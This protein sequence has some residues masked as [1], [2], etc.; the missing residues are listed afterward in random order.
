MQDGT[1]LLYAP[2]VPTAHDL[3]VNH[4]H[5]ADGD[6]AFGQALFRFF[7]G[8]MHEFVHRLTSN[9]ERWERMCNS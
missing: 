5:R 4:Q 3:S 1:A 8:G 7:D 2:I 9:N 6:A